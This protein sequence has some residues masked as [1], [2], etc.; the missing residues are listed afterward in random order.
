MLQT[1]LKVWQV[2]ERARCVHALGWFGGVYVLPDSAIGEAG[3][4]VVF[5]NGQALESALSQA[6]TVADWR[7]SVG[8]L[9]A[10]NSRPTF[11]IALAFAAPL[12]EL[13]GV[14]SG[15]FHLRGDSSKGKSTA[16]IV[17][18]SVW[19]NPRSYVRQW[20][21]TSNGT[22]G[23]AQLHNDGLLVL[24]EI[25][26][27]KE[28]DIGEIAYMLANGQGKTRA[29]RGGEARDAARWRLL[30]LS[31]GEKTL[32]AIMASAGKDVTAGQEIRMVDIEADAGARLGLYDQLNGAAGGADLSRR[33]TEAACSSFGTVGAEFLRRVVAHRADLAESLRASID[34]FTAKHLPAGA[35]GQVERVARRFGLVA[36]AGELARMYGLVPWHPGD[37]TNAA[38]ACFASWLVSFG[39]VGNREERPI[40][41]G[42]GILRAARGKPIR[43]QER[44]P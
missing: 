15:G 27:A 22:E 35:A 7:D 5:Q 19:G 20:R 31:T 40:A 41:P 37:S 43:E 1:Y 42:A 11:C 13:S 6:G 30:F 34:A 4:R 9:A 8:R 18:A 23:L 2:E 21:T 33:F 44:R 25:N 28:S 12:L 10:G 38:A 29:G 26:Q 3:E 24:D 39:G 32:S 16:G 17:A 14:D 36:Y